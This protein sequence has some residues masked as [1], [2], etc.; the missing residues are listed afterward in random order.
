MATIKPLRPKDVVHARKESIPNEM[1]EAF[2]ELIVEKF[3]GNSATIKLKEAADR[4]VSKGIDRHEAFNRGW[5]DVE[6]IF[7]QQG[8]HVEFDKPG[9]N[10]SYDA[11]YE[12]R[13][14]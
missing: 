1:I 6:D 14:K 7:R 5:F 10:E 13:A 3:N 2:N 9:Y 4:V 8:W 12:F 11:Y